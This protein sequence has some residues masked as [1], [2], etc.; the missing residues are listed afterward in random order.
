MLK[1]GVHSLIVNSNVEE[2]C[3]ETNQRMEASI[4]VNLPTKNMEDL[5]K[6]AYKHW[7]VLT[8]TVKPLSF[9]IIREQKEVRLTTNAI[10]LVV[11]NETPQGDGWHE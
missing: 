8:Q 5:L 3:V 6:K 10:T 2:R 11:K 9:T 7:S 1:G 4:E